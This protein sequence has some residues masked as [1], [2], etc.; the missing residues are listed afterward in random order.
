MVESYKKKLAEVNH[1]EQIT[2]IWTPENVGSYSK[3]TV[4][5]IDKESTYQNV[6]MGR[7]KL[8]L[9]HKGKEISDVFVQACRKF[10]IE[11]KFSFVKTEGAANTWKQMEITSKDHTI[12]LGNVDDSSTSAADYG[13][14]EDIY[15]GIED[16]S[17]M[18]K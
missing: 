2:N 13:R 6:T 15:N 1:V 14:D 3:I 11:Q 10:N 5:F 7:T 12:L 4:L 16:L 9:C 17:H 8:D 18:D